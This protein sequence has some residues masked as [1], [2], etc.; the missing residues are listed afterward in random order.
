MRL[1]AQSY[2]N[3]YRNLGKLFY[4]FAAIDN[5]VR[6]EEIERLRILVSENWLPLEESNDQ[7]GSDAAFQIE[8]QFDALNES[9]ADAQ[10][11]FKDFEKY[12]KSN[13]S[14]FSDEV[15]QLVWKTSDSVASAF[16]AKNKA[17]LV[18]LDQLRVLLEG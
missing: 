14:L 1:T 13:P 16:S 6:P 7:F 17:E 5:N 12:Y 2:Q 15:K 4:A 8:F 18:L 11:C 9:N 3:L 10:T